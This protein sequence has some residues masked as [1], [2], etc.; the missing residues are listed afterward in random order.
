MKR[1][2]TIVLKVGCGYLCNRIQ[3]NNF[4]KKY[5]IKPYPTKNQGLIIFRLQRRFF[6][7][8]LAK[9]IA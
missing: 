8:E 9:S 1:G 4:K 3:T 6:F 5:L 7:A 2:N